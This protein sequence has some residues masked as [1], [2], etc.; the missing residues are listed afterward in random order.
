MRLVIRLLVTL[1]TIAIFVLP[2]VLLGWWVLENPQPLRI[3]VA[4]AAIL[5]LLLIFYFFL[6]S[7]PLSLGK[8]SYRCNEKMRIT[9][10]NSRIFNWDDSFTL[11]KIGEQWQ[12]VEFSSKRMDGPESADIVIWEATAPEEPGTYWLSKTVTVVGDGSEREK[13]FRV[14]F[15]V[16]KW[17]TRIGS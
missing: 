10:K 7:S 9:L 6:S 11:E 14:R 15:N 8:P 3:F 4:V 1:I 13:T 2:F 12:P 16:S 5:V 17:S